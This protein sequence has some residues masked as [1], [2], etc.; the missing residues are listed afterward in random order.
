[1]KFFRSGFVV[2][3]A[4]LS[5]AASSATAATLAGDFD[6]ANNPGN[7]WEHGFN[8]TGVG[9]GNDVVNDV[10]FGLAKTGGDP[11]D[12]WTGDGTGNTDFPPNDLM[13]VNIGG[14]STASD[15]WGGG[16]ITWDAGVA[17]HTWGNTSAGGASDHSGDDTIYS[18]YT[19]LA[20]GDYDIVGTWTENGSDGG[21]TVDVLVNG[22]SIGSNSI[23]LNT[24]ADAAT[25]QSLSVALVSG[26]EVSFRT[27]RDAGV[28][29]G[30]SAR[31]DAS[32]VLAI[33]EPSSVLIAV[34]GLVGMTSGYRRR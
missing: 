4:F 16:A 3:V 28:T 23:D 10:A 6:V 5:A 29:V 8:D 26:D 11:G 7:D 34:P 20:D 19:V 30:G 21:A 13:L 24:D 2:A 9:A 17:Y 32:V 31:L 15:H 22:F 1:M 12:R 14:D 33:P 27:L 18:T 25:I